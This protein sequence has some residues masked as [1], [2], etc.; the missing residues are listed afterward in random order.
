MFAIGDKEWPGISK[1]TEEAGEV[2]QIVGKLMGTGGNAA[3]WNVPDLRQALINELGDLQAAIALVVGL[4]FNDEERK[5]L[6]ERAD[7]KLAIFL[8]WYRDTRASGRDP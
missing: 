7:Q 8:G 1:L 2:L 4:N 5:F 6:K 3:H